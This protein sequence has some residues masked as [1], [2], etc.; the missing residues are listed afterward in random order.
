MRGCVK[1]RDTLA[2]SCVRVT[3]VPVG[4]SKRAVRCGAAA[5]DQAS[6]AV[7]IRASRE[8]GVEGREQHQPRLPAV[9]GVEDHGARALALD[10]GAGGVDALHGAKAFEAPQGA[11][12][13]A[14][15]TQRDEGAVALHRQQRGAAVVGGDGAHQLVVVEA[16][17]QGAVLRVAN[18]DA[19][20]AVARAQK[21]H[22][23]LC[24]AVSV[25]V[26]HGVAGHRR[27]AVFEVVGVGLPAHL[28]GSGGVG[29]EQ[30]HAPRAEGGGAA[31][32]AVADGDHLGGGVGVELPHEQCGKRAPGP[33]AWSHDGGALGAGAGV[34]NADAVVPAGEH[35]HLGAAVAVE[36][37]EGVRVGAAHVGRRVEAEEL[38]GRREAGREV[39]AVGRV[40]V[41]DALAHVEV[42]V[43][44]A[45]EVDRAHA[46]RAAA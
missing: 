20:L 31:R 11:Q 46:A 40:G 1:G 44:V 8:R 45:V 19:P 23:D 16:G 2:P 42:E 13:R 18:L 24:G 10:G 21:A 14:L 25:E 41:V 32:E 35:Q 7:T 15:Q 27:G 5:T 38:T 37:D 17:A 3:V 9:V 29:V 43:A 6:S 33:R 4:A 12:R 28:Q 26:A 36:V 39:E 34:E 30:G 22:A